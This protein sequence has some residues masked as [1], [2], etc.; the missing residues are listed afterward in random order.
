MPNPWLSALLLAAALCVDALA[1]ATAY[2]A[3]GK[4]IPPASLAVVTAICT[5]LL[6]LSMLAGHSVA[7][8]LP[9]AAAGRL[10]GGI[11]LLIGLFKCAEGLFS[12]L[13]DRLCQRG[14]IRFSRRGL[15]FILQVYR[16]GTLADL[17]HSDRLSPAEGAYLALALSLDSLTA[18]FGTAMAQG[19]WLPVLLLCALLTLASLAGGVWLGQRLQAQ[20]SHR[21]AWAGGALLVALALFKLR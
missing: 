14:E 4:T 3:Q 5:G 12:D 19:G 16:D 9:P 2:G 21:C 8:W 11:L 13:A 17:D 7:A 6:G 10:G 1:A 20:L 18:G 15:R